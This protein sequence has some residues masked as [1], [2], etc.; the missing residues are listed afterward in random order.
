LALGLCLGALFAASPL[1]AAYRLHEAIVKADVPAIEA[2]VDWR[3]VRFSLKSSIS[4]V[5]LADAEAR[6]SDIGTL[7]R[8]GYRIGDAFAP[9]L[10]DRVIAKQV[11]PQG[12]VDYMRQP[13]PPGAPRGG[14]FKNIERAVYT[15]FSSFEIDV[16]DRLDRSRRYRAIFTRSRLT[17]RLTEVRLLPPKRTT[18]AASLTP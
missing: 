3:Q 14:M 1:I 11:T 17:W 13:L 16:R 12:F 2:A 15:G 9:F 10:I 4:E 6:R 8:I 5:M 18:L 7:R